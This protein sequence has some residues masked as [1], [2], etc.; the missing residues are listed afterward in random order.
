MTLPAVPS[1]SPMPSGS[2]I[3]LFDA[4]T[5]VGGRVKGKGME[6]DGSAQ[7]GHASTSRFDESVRT[8]QFIDF[9]TLILVACRVKVSDGASLF[10]AT[11]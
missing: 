11:P 1:S 9:P 6:A 10:Y 5:S 4:G 7:T 3:N 2:N 8:C